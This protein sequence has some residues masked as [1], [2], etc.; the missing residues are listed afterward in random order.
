MATEG[1]IF[2]R[3]PN[4][5]FRPEETGGKYFDFSIEGDELVEGGI[6]AD[7]FTD[8]REIGRILRLKGGKSFSANGDEEKTKGKDKFAYHVEG[9]NILRTEW[10]TDR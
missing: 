10:L 7:D 5:A 6:K 3:N 2:F 8:R 9:L 4:R 1:M